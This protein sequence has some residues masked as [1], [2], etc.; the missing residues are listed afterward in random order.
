M[1]SSSLAKKLQLKPG[2]RLIVM[3]P[4]P[5]YVESLGELPEGARLEEKASG[6]FDFVQ[7][8]VK[9]SA[10]LRRFAPKVARAVKHDGL[11]WISYPKRSAKVKTDLSRD[12]IWD[13]VKDEGL[14]GVSLIS[15][16]DTWSAMRFRPAERVGK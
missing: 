10:E 3:N 7:L 8:F 9:D 11:L 2:M 6:S 15:V 16:D 5:G 4:P 13:L 14:L 12:V 1:A